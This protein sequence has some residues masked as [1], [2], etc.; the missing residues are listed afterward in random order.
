MRAD[1]AE[2][3][4]FRA[5]SLNIFLFSDPF[6]PLASGDYVEFLFICGVV[7]RISV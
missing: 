2:F 1:A 5:Q 4:T 6:V 7:G 3:R